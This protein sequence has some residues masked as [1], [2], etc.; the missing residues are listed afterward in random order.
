[1]SSG[2]NTCKMQK[3]HSNVI[4]FYLFLSIT[5]ALCNVYDVRVYSSLVVV[6][7]HMHK[8]ISIF[9]CVLPACSVAHNR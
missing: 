9:F 6:S 5:S 3:Y 2:V 7:L 4:C 8:M 1:M